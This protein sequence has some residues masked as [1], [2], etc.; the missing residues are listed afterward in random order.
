MEQ[1]LSANRA[2]GSAQVFDDQRLAQA[3]GET[4]LDVAG[5][6]VERASRRIRDDQRRL[7]SGGHSGIDAL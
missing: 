4:G 3:F 7:F 5:C 6:D 1:A 2:A